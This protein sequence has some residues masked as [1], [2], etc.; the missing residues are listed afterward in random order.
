MIDYCL[1]P[2]CKGI[3]FEIINLDTFASKTKTY[4]CHNCGSIIVKHKHKTK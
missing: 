1:N 3:M 4:R 2:Q